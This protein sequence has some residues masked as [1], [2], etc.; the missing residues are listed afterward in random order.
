[1][2]DLP[3]WVKNV[4]YAL[5]GGMF[6]LGLAVLQA[7][8]GLRKISIDDRTALTAQLI[9][10]VADLEA[11]VREERRFCEERINQMAE[12]HNR[13]L[14]SRDRI[15]TELRERITALEARG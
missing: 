1:M 12:E 10:R 9:Q 14:E 8:V 11:G 15:I 13:R 4:G 2:D 6:T 5:S 3:E 7:K